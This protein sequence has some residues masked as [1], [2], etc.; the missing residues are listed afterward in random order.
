MKVFE[1]DGLQH[2]KP[3]EYFGG[4]KQFQD[5]VKKDNIKNKFCK[6]NNIKITR[7]TYRTT[8]VI[9]FKEFVN[10]AIKN[11][12]ESLNNKI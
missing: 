8:N 4:E 11:I 10:V 2:E 12:L 6:D 7:I 9:E 3:I 1:I 5:T